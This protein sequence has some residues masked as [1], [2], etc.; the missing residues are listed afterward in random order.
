MIISASM[1][2]CGAGYAPD[3][4]ARLFNVS[5]PSDTDS[6]PDLGSPNSLCTDG[7]LGQGAGGILKVPGSSCASLGNILI[8]QKSN[9]TTLDNNF[10][11]GVLCY[12][13]KDPI[14]DLLIARVDRHSR[15]TG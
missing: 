1:A 5:I 4:L 12:E 11:G 13:F 6:N 3:G 10:A 15:I 14:S 9:K 2:T 8:I 7:G